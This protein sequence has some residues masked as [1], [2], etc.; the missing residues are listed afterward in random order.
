MI[1]YGSE[2]MLTDEQSR[3]RKRH[4][5]DEDNEM[6]DGAEPIREEEPVDKLAN[7]T[8]LYVGNL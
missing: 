4:H 8:T 3:K 5:R 1:Y 6:Q 2:A 7:A